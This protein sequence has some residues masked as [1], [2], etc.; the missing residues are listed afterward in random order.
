MIEMGKSVNPVYI[1]F[2]MHYG[3]QLY[4]LK[5]EYMVQFQRFDS[6]KAPGFIQVSILNKIMDFNKIP[7]E[8]MDRLYME[9]NGY[10]K[11]VD[12]LEFVDY[13]KLLGSVF[14]KSSDMH[15]MQMRKSVQ[16]ISRVKKMMDL[17]RK[18]RREREA[19]KQLEKQ[20]KISSLTQRTQRRVH[21]DEENVKTLR[22]ERPRDRGTDKA[23]SHVDLKTQ[24]QNSLANEKQDVY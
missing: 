16:V 11:S 21:I 2:R 18:K 13:N 15:E 1:K 17:R 12:S 8:A 10:T 6:E 14:K 19:E 3:G 4:K 5:D 22:K 20:V 9:K 23:R 24:L 7:L